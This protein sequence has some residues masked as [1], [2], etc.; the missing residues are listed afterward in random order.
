MSEGVKC[1][2]ILV[3]C[4]F[5][6][7]VEDIREAYRLSLGQKELDIAAGIK[8]RIQ[9]LQLAEVSGPM[10]NAA[11]Q[12]FPDTD[13]RHIKSFGSERHEKL[14]PVAAPSNDDDA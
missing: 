8:Q 7:P 3:N 13:F 14:F 11:A 4:R 2:D 9:A 5:F 1:T 10:R 12:M 6:H